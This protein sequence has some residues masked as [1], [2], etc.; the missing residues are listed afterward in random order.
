MKVALVK[1]EDRK[2]NISKA[3]HRLADKDTLPSF[4]TVL[5]K[6]NLTGSEGIYCNTSK[7]A[8]RAIID[9][10]N[11]H[12]R[13]QQIFVGEGSAGA[14][15]SRIS[16]RQVFKNMSYEDLIKIE[17]VELMNVDELPHEA[18]FPVDT[19]EGKQILHLAKPEV[20]LII[21]LAL[22]K[23]HDLAIATLGMKNM[24]GLIFPEDRHKIH[25]YC[26]FLGKDSKR[27]FK[28]DDLYI[29]SVEKIHR[30]LFTLF[31]MIRPDLTIIDGYCGM[32]GDGPINGEPL[33]H[34]FALASC[35][36]IAADFVAAQLMGLKPKSIGYLYYLTENFDQGWS[37]EVLG[38]D[39]EKLVKNYKLHRKYPLQKQWGRYLI[40]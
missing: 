4:Q 25:G 10:L 36:A 23:T 26:D 14:Y 21:S 2:K 15:S 17:N 29:Q 38:S 12:Y 32:E 13:P 22:P 30:N 28:D 5:I 8:V 24:M 39:P 33:F 7:D 6:P 27:L 20:D 9:F 19:Y 16:T 1:G 31:N 35:D 34:G 18:V 3:L 37:P 40:H 11:V